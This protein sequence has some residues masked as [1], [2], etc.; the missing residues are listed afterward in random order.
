MVE[1][2]VQSGG[3]DHVMVPAE[4]ETEDIRVSLVLR[5][6]LTAAVGATLERSAEVGVKLELVDPAADAANHLGDPFAL[7]KLVSLLAHLVALR[8]TGLKLLPVPVLDT[9]ASNVLSVEE[10]DFLDLW[11]LVLIPRVP[12][13]VAPLCFMLRA[14][15]TVKVCFL[16]VWL[17]G[18]A[19]SFRFVF[20]LTIITGAKGLANEGI[21]TYSEWSEDEDEEDL[22]F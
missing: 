2:D 8:A 16:P 5:L 20:I 21:F 22:S 9:D 13:L 19:R 18:S 11:Q 4:V 7:L 15:A 3:F 12:N 1:I 17:P 6:A 14:V 10:G